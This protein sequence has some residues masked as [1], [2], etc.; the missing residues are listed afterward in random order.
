MYLDTHKVLQLDV[1]Y[2]LS[3]AGGTGTETETGGEGTS[4][5]GG[6]NSAGQKQMNMRSS[7]YALVRA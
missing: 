6:Y 2:V 5:V 7:W 3:E 4:T 1:V